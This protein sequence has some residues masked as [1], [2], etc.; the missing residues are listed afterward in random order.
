MSGGAEVAAQSESGVR[1]YA[2]LSVNEGPA[3]RETLGLSQ[4]DF[5][6]LFGFNVRSLQDWEQGR[7]RPEIPIRAYL[8][9]I[10]RDPQAII[11]ALRAT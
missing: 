2:A 6:A 9:V 7:R 11:R 5:A 1:R 4:T 10:Q 8:A 3:L